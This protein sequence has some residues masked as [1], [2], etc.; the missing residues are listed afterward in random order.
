[1]NIINIKRVIK[2]G[3]TRQ[4]YDINQLI[5]EINTHL[6]HP[7]IDRKNREKLVKQEIT[8]N[9]GN[10]GESIGRYIYDLL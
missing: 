9:K 5:N 8:I 10:A 3:A 7:H 6:K 4:V 1:M 2:T